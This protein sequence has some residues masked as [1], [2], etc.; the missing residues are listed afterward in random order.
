MFF[1]G[2]YNGEME[3][4]EILPLFFPYYNTFFKTFAADDAS[5][6]SLSS[7]SSSWQFINSVHLLS[8]PLLLQKRRKWGE[9]REGKRS[10]NER[11]KS[12]RPRGK[13]KFCPNGKGDA[14][15]KEEETKFPFSLESRGKE[16][17][18]EAKRKER[19]RGGE[20]A[21]LFVLLLLLLLRSH[22]SE[23]FYCRY[24]NGLSLP[25]R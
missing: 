3:V 23:R 12:F 1:G 14:S 11:R 2:Q 22:K 21:S 13:E 24:K 6:L 20:D 10:K 17:E 9:G 7:S 18:G 25:L 5:S 16:G 4:S 19:G 15:K 8:S